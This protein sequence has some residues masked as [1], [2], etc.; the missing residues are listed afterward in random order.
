M[1]RFT[2]L[3]DEERMRHEEDDLS[4]APEPD[5]GELEKHRA[6]HARN[7]PENRS[8][9]IN[10][11]Q[12][13]DGGTAE[14]HSAGSAP[15]LAASE[16]PVPQPEYQR[17][18]D[19]RDQLLDRVVRL[20]AEFDNYRKRET[21][22]R[23]EFREYAMANAVERFLPV[24]DN[25]QLALGAKGTAE[26]LR[27]GVELIVRQMEEIVRSLGVEPVPAVETQFDPRVHEAVEMV[28]RDD[29]PDRQVLEEIRRG[30][31]LRD[32]LLRPAMVRVA[33]NPK[34]KSE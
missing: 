29:V 31:T 19:E 28:D 4:G 20:Q 12:G 11:I 24:I 2:R 30:Y 17:L 26:Q 9:R 18:R 14:S 23:A 1:P 33:N 21:R 5:S 27:S 32:R 10:E 6:R 34:Q 16:A 8:K 15:E 22:E 3:E 7:N 25:F 13:A